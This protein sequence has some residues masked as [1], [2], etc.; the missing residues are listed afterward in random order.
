M[1]G[2]DLS[3]QAQPSSLLNGELLPPC[4]VRQAGSPS[5]SSMQE[6]AD[7]AVGYSSMGSSISREHIRIQDGMEGVKH[8]PLLPKTAEQTWGELH[9]RDEQATEQNAC[10]FSHAFSWGGC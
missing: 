9:S 2:A 4:A 7:S 8:T 5:H 6:A 1:S 10:P 3:L